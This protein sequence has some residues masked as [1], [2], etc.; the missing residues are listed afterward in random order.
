[1][2]ATAQGRVNRRTAAALGALVLAMAVLAYASVPLYRLFCQVTGFGGTTQ[3]AS[4]IAPVAIDQHVVVRFNADVGRGMPWTFHPSQPSID[5]RLGE[6]VLATYVA[7]N[8]TAR[9]ITGTATFNVTPEKVG[10]YFVK[11]ECFCFTEQTLAP[12]ERVEMPVVFYV[13]PALADDPSAREVGTI[14][15]SYTFFETEPDGSAAN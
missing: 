7:L 11:V 3:V 14:T 10:R 12:G 1:M 6:T 8:P 15:L 9:T 4:G 5:A 13:D 2:S